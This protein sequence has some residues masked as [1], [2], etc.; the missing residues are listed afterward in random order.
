MDMLVASDD[1]SMALK[2]YEN[3]EIIE[4][5]MKTINIENKN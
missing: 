1:Q 3:N 4:N 2:Q 5:N